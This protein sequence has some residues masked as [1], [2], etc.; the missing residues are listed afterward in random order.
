MKIKLIF[1]VIS[2][3]FLASPV[4]G[5]ATSAGNETTEAD[6]FARVALLGKPISSE[7]PLKVDD[8]REI[9]FPNINIAAVEQCRLLTGQKN[10][11]VS[12]IMMRIKSSGIIF[13]VKQIKSFAAMGEA[14]QYMKKEYD[15]LLA[16][17]GDFT[18]GGVIGGDT[19]SAFIAAE[20]NIKA[21]LVDEQHQ[22]SVHYQTQ[23]EQSTIKYVLHQLNNKQ[24]LTKKSGKLCK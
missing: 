24:P 6:R 4:F 18:K 1:T 17:N 2:S 12:I 13:G 7:L 10:D 15:R 11:S 20:G 3:L 9:S 19:L 21:N 16:E 23:Q 14:R 22:V 8:C 5:Q